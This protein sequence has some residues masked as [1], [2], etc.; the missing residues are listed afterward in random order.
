MR[1]TFKGFLFLRLAG[2]LALAIVVAIVLGIRSVA[3]GSDVLG[4][5]ILAVAVAVAVA[6]GW[7]VARRAAGP[8]R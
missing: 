3:R 1:E 5:A 4:I 6:T 2:L 7:L 8:P